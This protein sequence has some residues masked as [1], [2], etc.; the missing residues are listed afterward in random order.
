MRLRKLIPLVLLVG[1]VV[2][3][4]SARPAN[5]QSFGISASPPTGTAIA[6]G[7]TQLAV[8]AMNPGGAPISILIEGPPGIETTF[9]PQEAL[10]DTIF[11][12]TVRVTSDLAPGNYTLV[13]Q[14]T[15]D[16]QIVDELEWPLV[17]SAAARPS[18]WPTGAPGT[19][20]TASATDD[21]GVIDNSGDDAAFLS[22]L[23]LIAITAVVAAL[24][25]ATLQ[26]RRR[27]VVV[28]GE[29]WDPGSGDRD[30]KEGDGGPRRPRWPWGK[31]PM[32]GSGD[33]VKDGRVEVSATVGA[34]TEAVPTTAYP[35]IEAPDVAVMQEEFAVRVGLSE[36]KV[37]GVVGGEM[38]RPDLDSG[39][40]R[41]TVKVS[42]QGLTLRPD[43]LW[44]NVLLVTAEDPY[45][46]AELH[47]TPEP[48]SEP[49][50]ATKITADYMIG[51]QPMGMGERQ[52]TVIQSEVFRNQV[53]V[54]AEQEVGT[55]TIP[56][57]DDPPDLL[58]Y[59]RAWSSDRIKWS[60]QTCFDDLQ[61]NDD[62]LFSEVDGS[63]EDFAKSLVETVDEFDNVSGIEE[64]IR[65]L[66]K[67]IGDLV[68]EPFWAVLKD[69]R[70]RRKRAPS[71]LIMSTEGSIPW[72]L[73]YVPRDYR[74]AGD[75]EFLGSQAAIGRWILAKRPPAPSCVPVRV[76]A[77][78]VIS[79]TYAGES[80]LAGAESESTELVSKYHA[81]AINATR[82]VVIAYLRSLK[83]G[84]VH[85]AIHGQFS[86]SAARD[87]L[88]MIDEDGDKDLPI[89]SK[90]VGGLEFSGNPFIFI[91]AC[92]VGG[93][94][95]SL[96]G[97]AGMAKSFLDAGAC[98]LVAPLWSISDSV[99]VKVSR[100]FYE[101][102]FKKTPPA[103][104]LRRQKA[105]FM[106]RGGYRSA[107]CLAYQYYGH[108]G[109]VLNLEKAGE[110]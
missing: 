56:R 58:V 93:G 59:L 71:V 15:Y 29:R 66:A 85:F 35:R 98:G 63:P 64:T 87:G 78:G 5:A 107:T 65:G 49:V 94:A 23:V 7:E 10:S 92:Q 97:Y 50:A 68:P 20:V 22:P 109:L 2:V 103:E 16:K 13:I 95:K 43:E 25:F 55:I 100:A 18:I 54:W 80:R 51:S 62:A 96:G 90:F 14:Q 91:N 89:N 67:D 8:G 83:D 24:G 61:I 84:L 11:V 32:N 41:L 79:G 70:K 27:E 74:H 4:G 75:G 19:A 99:S 36:E 3:A 53:D 6:G 45:P 73:A 81:S 102:V 33:R 21:P 28:V 42:A 52:L 17:V 31:G 108:P 34:A 46:F 47:M 106:R 69:V 60:V 88:L 72:E 39:P 44:T 9:E 1:I 38:R 30:P 40:Y 101:S 37:E 76:N 104:A 105:L 86:G 57:S 26:A 12:V 82:K 48:Q 110:K 77:M